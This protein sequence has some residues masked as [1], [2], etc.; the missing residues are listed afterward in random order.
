MFSGIQRTAA[1]PASDAKK[2]S[3]KVNEDPFAVRMA[4]TH[5]GNTVKHKFSAA[6]QHRHEEKAMVR[7]GK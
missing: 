7:K 2:S 1:T 3:T 4:A 6:E 5:T